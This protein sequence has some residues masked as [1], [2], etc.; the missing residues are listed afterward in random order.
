MNRKEFSIT[1]LIVIYAYL[2]IILNVNLNNLMT[3]QSIDAKAPFTFNA[4]MR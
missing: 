2:A 1:G 3:W 4:F